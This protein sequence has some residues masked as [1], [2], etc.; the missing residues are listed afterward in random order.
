M[1]SLIYHFKRYGKV[2]TV[3]VHRITEEINYQTGDKE[4]V[5][6]T[7]KIPRAV[8]F[9]INDTRAK[10]FNLLAQAFKYGAQ[11]DVRVRQFLLDAIDAVEIKDYIV[12]LGQKDR[13]EVF[14]IDTLDDVMI[15]SCKAVEGAKREAVIDIAV[16]SHVNAQQEI[17]KE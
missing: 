12:V 10:Q 1:E 3:I 8:A 17:T 2:V 6:T 14:A 16:E 9:P 11:F 5:I 4:R 13:W 15:V 7:K